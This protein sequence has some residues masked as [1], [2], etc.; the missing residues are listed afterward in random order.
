MQAGGRRGGMVT[1][2]SREHA[3]A[4][5]RL[6]SAVAHHL[7]DCWHQQ[8]LTLPEGQTTA[9]INGERPR[10]SPAHGLLIAS[11]ICQDMEGMVL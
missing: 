1:R 8:T 7:G 9:L 6:Y 2:G 10:C 3:T 11:D 5:R 4:L